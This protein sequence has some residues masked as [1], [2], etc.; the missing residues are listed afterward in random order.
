MRASVPPAAATKASSTLRRRSLAS[1]PP[2]ANKVPDI[3]VTGG[4]SRRAG[5]TCGQRSG[6]CLI[7]RSAR[8]GS[9]S[10]A[11]YFVVARQRKACRLTPSQ[12]GGARSAV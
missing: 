10:G 2:I 3:S 5:E 8:C 4:S 9:R 11:A 1:A 6:R 7:A 12:H